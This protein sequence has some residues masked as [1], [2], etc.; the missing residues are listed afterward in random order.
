MKGFL[1][2]F[3]ISENTGYISGDDGKRYQFTGKA[4]KE[5]EIP[6][7]GDRVDFDIKAENE[8][9]AVFFALH[10]YNEADPFTSLSVSS[11]G[12]SEEPK[13]IE[14]VYVA[15]MC[16]EEKYNIFE[17][18]G[19]SMV[20]YFN[21]SGRARRKEYWYFQLW[22]Y[23]LIYLYIFCEYWLMLNNPVFLVE[24]EQMIEI[25]YMLILILN[26]AIFFPFLAVTARRLHDTGK[27]AWWMLLILTGVGIIPLFILC[28]FDTEAQKNVWGRPAKLSLLN[29]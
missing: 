2:L 17:W 5:K 16:K 1:L 15:R 23:V 11:N 26:L 6:R 14:D 13:E 12:V 7:K 8:A 10:R 3:S 20:N 21:F 18:F 24:S 19:H 4:W 25:S 28:S 27:S 22:T 9:T 29:T